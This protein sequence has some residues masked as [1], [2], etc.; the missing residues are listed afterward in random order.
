[1]LASIM[2]RIDVDSGNDN[3]EDTKIGVVKISVIRD[4]M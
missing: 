4:D 2:Q 1:M 3:P